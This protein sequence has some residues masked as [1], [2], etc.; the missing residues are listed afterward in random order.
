MK[1]EQKPRA[2]SFLTAVSWLYLALSVAMIGL[3]IYALTSESVRLTF[4]GVTDSVFAVILGALGCFAAILG[5]IGRNLRRCRILGLVL[6]LVSAVPLTINLLA[7]QPFSIY[8]KNVAALIVPFLYLMA[9]LF[10][11][12]KKQEPSAAEAEIVPQSA[13]DT[14]PKTD[15]PEPTG[16]GKTD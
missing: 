9:A 14:A 13:A 6:L 2:V 10:T 4:G 15:V 5:L 16:D 7:A 1:T 8:W 11:R 12:A 3:A